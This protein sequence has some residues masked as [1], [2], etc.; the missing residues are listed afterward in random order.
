MVIAKGQGNF[1]TLQA[2]GRDIFFL[3][4]VKCS[5][6]AGETGLPTGSIFFHHGGAA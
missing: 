2:C 6:V 3:M 5:V 4:K 1:E